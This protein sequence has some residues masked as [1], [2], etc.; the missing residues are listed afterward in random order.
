MLGF[1]TKYPKSSK[2]YAAK[3]MS[4]LTIYAFLMMSKCNEFTN[5]LL[6]LQ[7]LLFL[8]VSA[9]LIHSQLL[10]QEHTGHQQFVAQIQGITVSFIISL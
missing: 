5:P 2:I 6:L 1:N 10:P 3:C 7:M 4:S 8:L 9:L